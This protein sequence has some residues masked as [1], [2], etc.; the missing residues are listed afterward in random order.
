MN[1]I[2]IHK[3]IIHSGV[4]DGK[5]LRGNVQPLL[6]LYHGLSI[7]DTVMISQC[8]SEQTLLKSSMVLVLLTG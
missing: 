1:I 6:T 4:S 7:R 8:V 3:Y 5:S 2:I